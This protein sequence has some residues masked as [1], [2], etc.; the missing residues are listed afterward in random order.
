MIAQHT[1]PLPNGPR[2][3]AVRYDHVRVLVEPRLLA[4]ELD[5]A[6]VDSAPDEPVI[7]DLQ[8]SIM[9]SNIGLLLLPRTSLWVLTLCAIHPYSSGRSSLVKASSPSLRA[10]DSCFA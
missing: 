5:F 8:R 4:D 6:Q 10:R 1:D 2:A 7:A 9:D 3:G